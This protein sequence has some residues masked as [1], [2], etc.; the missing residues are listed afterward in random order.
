MV[1]DHIELV[2]TLEIL[3]LD[4]LTDGEREREI[5]KREREREIEIERDR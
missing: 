3:D 4:R 5:E 2:L 1:W